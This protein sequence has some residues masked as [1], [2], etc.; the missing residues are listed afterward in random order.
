MSERKKPCGCTETEL[1]P[2][3]Y[4]A[5]MEA[6]QVRPQSPACD[7]CSV[8]VMDATNQHLYGECQCPCHTQPAEDGED[9][10]EPDFTVD[11]DDPTHPGWE[12]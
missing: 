3:H 7:R 12:A 5:K 8:G 10:G 11:P 2:D 1:C 6:R 4:A 9:D